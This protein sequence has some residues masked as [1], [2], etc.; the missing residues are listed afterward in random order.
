[1]EAGYHN[2]TPED[3]AAA[4]QHGDE[5]ALA[6][7][8]R[9]FHPVLSHY[10]HHWVQSRPIAE[11]IA[12][13]ALIKT[14]R[15]HHKLDSYG[16]IRAYLY[17][18][19]RNASLDSLEQEQKKAKLYQMAQPGK[20]THDT[21]F[22][23]LVRSETYRI[24]HTALKQLSPAN[25]KVI[26]MHYLEG[27]TTGQIATELNLHPSTVKTQKLKGLQALRKKLL[28]PLLTLLYPFVKIFLFI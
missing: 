16:A 17:K 15:M 4:F 22:D 18:T 5:Q 19:V 9:E 21:P 13:E 3:Y 1:M 25:R 20:T 11:E 2:W 14:W 10:A 8:Y 6:F 7:I 27:K 12:S 24:I 26:I 28:R 23:Q